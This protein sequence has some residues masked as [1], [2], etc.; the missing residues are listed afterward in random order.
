MICGRFKTASLS[1]PAKDSKSRKESVTC[2]PAMDYSL[3]C[4]PG[5]GQEVYRK[6]ASFFEY[7]EGAS[8]LPASCFKPVSKAQGGWG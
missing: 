4:V 5:M 7:P 3:V 6:V 1:A 8:P 2:K